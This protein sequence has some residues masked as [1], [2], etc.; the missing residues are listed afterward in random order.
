MACTRRICHTAPVA[1]SATS[2]IAIESLV[3]M[4]RVFIFVSP[5]WS[6][7]TQN[8]SNTHP[9]PQVVL[10]N[11]CGSLCDLCGECFRRLLHHRVTEDHR[12]SLRNPERL[13]ANHQRSCLAFNKMNLAR[14]DAA[15]NRAR[16]GSAERRRFVRRDHQDLDA[17]P[18]APGDHATRAAVNRHSLARFEGDDCCFFLAS[19]L[20][21][22]KFW[23]DDARLC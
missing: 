23:V 2:A 15:E 21:S 10:T 22:L 17:A 1:A 19:H 8:A 7:E 16:I 4:F 14:F 12:G 13:A 18:V 6:N 11:L 20:P 5:F 9:L 3:K